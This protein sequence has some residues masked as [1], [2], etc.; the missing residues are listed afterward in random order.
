MKQ[1]VC[2]IYGGRS[3]EHEVS[4]TSAES[5]VSALDKSKY[6]TRAIAISKTGSWIPDIMP[7]EYRRRYLNNPEPQ[8]GV[9]F[10]S[11]IFKSS[12]SE[13]EVV[14]PVLHGPF[15][16]DGTMQGLLEMLDLPYVGS[17]VL[18]SALAMDKAATKYMCLAYGIPAVEFLDFISSQWD[19]EPESVMDSIEENIGYPCFVKPA[20]LG[21][22]IG[23]T[24]ACD[25][26]ALKASI[27]EA[28]RYDKKIIVERAVNCREIE[29]SIL[30]NDE[31]EASLAGEII[32]CNEFYD[33]NAKYIDGKSQLVIPAQIDAD[34]HEQVQ[35]ISIQ[36]FKALCCFGMARADFLLD[37]D[38]GDLYFSEINTIPGFTSISMYPKLWEA[39]GLPYPQLL[40]RL[41]ELALERF[42]GKQKIH[43]NLFQPGGMEEK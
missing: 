5:V 9:K 27:C 42:E 20:N 18:G 23:I 7:V 15:G 6:D 21:S 34:V 33:Y 38:T 26:N 22:S 41:I 35:N 13:P 11:E 3:G 25:S 19:A 12:I 40:D 30:G 37:K 24:K 10:S 14:I 39:S 28:F 32:P 29:C 17:G 1:K 2:V 36:A 8:R 16:E 43:N 31:P 4:V